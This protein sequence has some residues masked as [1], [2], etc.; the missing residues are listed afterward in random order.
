MELYIFRHAEAEDR[1]PGLE[2]Q[3][4]KL[5]PRGRRDAR[6]VAKVALKAR[7]LPQLILTSPLQRARETAAI[8]A[9]VLGNVRIK[10]TLALLPDALPEQLWNELCA[11]PAGIEVAMLVGHEPH[12]GLLVQFLLEAHIRVRVRKGAL[13]KIVAG[14]RQGT[15][16]GQLD[17]MIL[18]KMVRRG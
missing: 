9:N 6:A 10:E 18:P 4:R 11:M 1:R 8:A 15:P 7:E 14:G 12:T 13:I 16:R 5:T 17:W 2:D 3:D